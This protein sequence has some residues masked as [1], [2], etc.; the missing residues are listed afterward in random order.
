[1]DGLSEKIKDILANHSYNIKSYK[2]QEKDL[3]SEIRFYTKHNFEEEKRIT[4]VKHSAINMILYDY[5]EMFN[6]IEKAL[7]NNN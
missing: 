6:E 1:M 3:I 7:N 2:E 4:I 5:K